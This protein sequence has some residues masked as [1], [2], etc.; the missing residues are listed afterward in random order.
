MSKRK[1]SVTLMIGGEARNLK[2]TMST[3]ELYVNE[4]A[5]IVK[6]NPE[7]NTENEFWQMKLLF[8]CA[9]VIGDED[10]NGQAGLNKLPEELSVKQV[11]KWIDD[12]EDENF[13]TANDF[14]IECMGFISSA[15]LKT[16]S[17]RIEQA[18]AM[19]RTVEDLVKMSES[20]KKS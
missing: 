6:E 4:L 19:G 11:G 18:K 15:E 20:S 9:L 3:Q 17:R 7:T 8:F 10:D 14:A 12:C 2:F 16:F 13:D 5:R 1:N